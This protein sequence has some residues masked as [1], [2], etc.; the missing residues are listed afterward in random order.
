[1]TFRNIPL[2]SKITITTLSGEL[3]RELSGNTTTDVVWDVK[4]QQGG[5]LASGAYYYRVDF[6]SG[7]TS[8]KLAIIK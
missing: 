5:F 8:G 2:S 6:P 3:I 4:N 1:M 7:S